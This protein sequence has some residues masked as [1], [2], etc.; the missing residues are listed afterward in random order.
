[1]WDRDKEINET[2]LRARR[3]TLFKQG[4]NHESIDHLFEQEEKAEQEKQQKA[5]LYRMIAET[6]LSDIKD[7]EIATELLAEKKKVLDKKIETLEQLNKE[8]Q[9][10]EKERLT[11]LGLAETIT[12]EYLK[13]LDN[14]GAVLIIASLRDNQFTFHTQIMPNPIDISKIKQIKI[15]AGE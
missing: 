2:S 11:S 5:N 4:M 12:N 14:N 10:M 8:I 9:A 6:E 15:E 1:M 7:N 3:V 13:H